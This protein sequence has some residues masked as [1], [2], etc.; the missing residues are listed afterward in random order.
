MNEASKWVAVDEIPAGQVVYCSL[1]GRKATRRTFRAADTN[2]AEALRLAT[3]YA[4]SHEHSEPHWAAVDAFHGPPPAV[5]P[6][7]A[8]LAEIFGTPLPDERAQRRASAR[9]AARRA[10]LTN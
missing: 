1:C 10:R 2:Y 3:A 7:E 4:W 6:E 8:L 5:S 9:L